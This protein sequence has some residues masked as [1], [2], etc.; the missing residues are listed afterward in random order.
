MAA[1]SH[2]DKYSAVLEVH[3]K[4]LE[5]TRKSDPTKIHDFAASYRNIAD[6]DNG[7]SK[8]VKIGAI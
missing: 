8:Y 6:G 3:E 2:V 4:L 5:I 1:H 7:M